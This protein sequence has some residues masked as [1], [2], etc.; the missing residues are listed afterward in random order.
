MCC[1]TGCGH[2]CMNPVKDDDDDDEG[3]VKKTLYI[4][5][6]NQLICINYQNQMIL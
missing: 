2:V 3:I 4:V 5:M 1:S 6:D